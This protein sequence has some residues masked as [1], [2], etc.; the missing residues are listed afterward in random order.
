MISAAAV[1]LA[2]AFWAPYN[3]GQ[4]VCPGGVQIHNVASYSGDTPGAAYARRED[5]EL[6]P[7]CEVFVTAEW[8]RQPRAVQ[9]AFV[10]RALGASWF[11][12]SPSDD[13]RNVMYFRRFVV[14]GACKT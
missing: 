1:T 6:Q 5:G 4:P 3:H 13:W 8:R 2:L 14:P 9:C 11:G 10:A 7:N 12:L